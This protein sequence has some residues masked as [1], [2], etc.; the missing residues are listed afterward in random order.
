MKLTAIDGSGFEAHHTSRYFV[1]RR[2]KGRQDK[3][4]MTYKRFPKM[5]LV[6]D[7]D[8]HLILAAATGRG[9]TPDHPHLIEAMLDAAA[10]RRIETVLADAGY[11]GE[12]VHEFLRDE[13]DIRSII[14]PKIGRPTAKP[15]KGRYRRLMSQYF[16]RPPEARRYG[17][18]WQVET[19][20]S[21][22]KRRL[23]ETVS[24]RSY[25][26]QN[27]ALLLKAITHN[28][29]ILLWLVRFSTEQPGP[30]LDPSW[31]LTVR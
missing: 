15:P 14:P 17:Q 8:S 25:H 6:C 3:T 9:P 4:A 10:R 21:M 1:R 12:W 2:A 26:R 27:R 22:I 19:V 11:D 5:G 28:V 20:F 16:K 29:L 23:G 13:L 30:F 24:A 18:R 7:C 31:R